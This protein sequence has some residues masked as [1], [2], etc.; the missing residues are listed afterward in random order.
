MPPASAC[1]CTVLDSVSVFCVFV[2]KIQLMP[3]LRFSRTL[4]CQCWLEH[5]RATMCACLLTAKQDLE[6]HIP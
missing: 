1:L 2:I 3:L 4:A 6:R 5:L